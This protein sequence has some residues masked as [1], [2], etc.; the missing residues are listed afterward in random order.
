M[1]KAENLSEDYFDLSIQKP[2]LDHLVTN[3]ERQ[4]EDKSVIS[5]FDI[6]NPKNLPEIPGVA[7][8]E[9]QRFMQYRNAEVENLSKH[10]QGSGVLRPTEECIEEWST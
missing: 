9:M 5:A 1:K 10:C 8:V 6:F 2:F 3:L 7:D 4:F